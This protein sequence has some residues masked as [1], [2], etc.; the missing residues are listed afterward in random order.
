M[1][2][3]P[4]VSIIINNY[5]YD[6]FVSQAIDSALNQTYS[7]LEVIVVDDG[8]TDN[9]QKI[10]GNYGNSIIPVFKENGDHAS[11]FNAGFLASSG[12]IIC[13]LDADD[14][15]LPEKVT[16]VVEVFASHLEIGWCF[17]PL[18]L[19]NTNNKEV[20]GVT[21]AF[22]QLNEDIS[23]SCDFRTQLRLGKLSF[24]PPS[25]SALCFRRSLLKQILP[26]PEILRQ[27]A[28]R[29]LTYGTLFL[30]PGFF[31]DRELTI[32]G[33]HST[34]DGTLQQ[35]QKFRQKKARNQV[36]AAY[37]LRSKFPE[38]VK[39]TNRLFARGFS[40]YLFDG[41][42]QGEEKKLIDDYYKSATLSTK[43]TILLIAIYHSRP[44]KKV[45][46]YKSATIE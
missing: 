25:T 15:F 14:R 23:T 36:V 44:W 41:I 9:S 42:K 33:I 7:S 40:Y 8:S 24:Y 32:Q 39:F 18:K 22:P 6:R 5:N 37:L 21:R 1:V 43:L 20:L 13:C 29:Y 11:T 46:L 27:A 31:L 35:G 28:D 12:E 2:K 26:M 16:Q 10:I 45:Q 19:V 3:Q 30:S 34:N 38:L 4:L 17:H